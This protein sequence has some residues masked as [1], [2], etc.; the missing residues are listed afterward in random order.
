MGF[1]LGACSFISALAPD[2]NSSSQ[3]SNLGQ[4]PE[5]TNTIWINTEGPLSLAK[6]RGQVVLLDMWTFG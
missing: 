3:L 6:L 2:K 1:F 4:A 5:L